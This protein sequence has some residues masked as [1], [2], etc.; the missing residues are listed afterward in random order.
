MAKIFDRIDASMSNW[1][2]QQKMFFVATAPSGPDGHINCSPKGHDSFR[3]LDE[4]TVAYRDLTGSGIETVAHVNE[5]GRI[6]IMFCAFDGSPKIVRLH[7]SAEVVQPSHSEFETLSD[8][9]GETHPSEK[10]GTRCFVRVNVSRIS[11]SCG[12]SVPQFDFVCE[13]DVLRKWNEKKGPEGI[14]AYQQS[15]NKVSIDGLPGLK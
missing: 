5:N 13:R 10:L 15:S 3:V 2:A 4:T 6:V 9:F 14:A 8:L 12:Y 1:I 11:D 7:G